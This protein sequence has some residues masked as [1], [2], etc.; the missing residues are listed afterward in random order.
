MQFYFLNLLTRMQAVNGTREL[1][2]TATRIDKKKMGF[3][4][5]SFSRKF[6]ETDGARK[7]MR[8][9]RDAISLNF[10]RDVIGAHVKN[11]L[12]GRE[13]I[14]SRR[15]LSFGVDTNH[16]EYSRTMMKI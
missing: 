16:Y 9:N 5:H 12:I 7:R 11:E 1:Q 4:R 3:S 6:Y 13:D 14:V 15:A 10:K 2:F 8:E